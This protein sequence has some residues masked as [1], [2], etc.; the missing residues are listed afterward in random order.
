MP[1][2]QALA[3]FYL[4]VH[5]L[6]TNGYLPFH[7]PENGDPNEFRDDYF[8]S[9]YPSFHIIA[10]NS[11]D[12][13]FFVDE[14]EAAQGFPV[15]FSFHDGDW[16]NPFTVSPG[17]AEFARF[18]LRLREVMETEQDS[19]QTADFVARHC[20]VAHNGF[21]QE[22]HQSLCEQKELEAEWASQEA[23]RQAKIASG[24]WV[25][26]SIVI[27]DLGDAKMKVAARMK[28]L[29]GLSTAEALAAANHLPI[30][31]RSGLWQYM[32]AHLEELH[33]WGVSAQFVPQ[34]EQ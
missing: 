32:R 34:S 18:L 33:S 3:A 8:G 26:G 23:R 19:S 30:L 11:M 29:H 10:L 7:Y 14:R 22:V 4:A 25:F 20:D 1:L 9:E 15:Y 13:F 24:D 12:D 16:S 17:L 21:W 6:E 28:Q 31:Y 5:G 2:P 27:T